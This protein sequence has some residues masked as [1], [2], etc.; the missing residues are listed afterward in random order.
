MPLSYAASKSRKDSARVNL[1]KSVD[2]PKPKAVVFTSVPNNVTLRM[3][4]QLLSSHAG[5]REREQAQLF[6]TDA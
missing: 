2:V 1:P 5:V 3:T 4:H 6:L